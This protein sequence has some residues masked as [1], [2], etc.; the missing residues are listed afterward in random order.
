MAIIVDFCHDADFFRVF[1]IVSDSFGYDQPYIDALFPN[2]H[3]HAG[4]I[5]GADRFLQMKRTDPTNRCLKATDTASGE[6]I[7]FAKWIVFAN[8]K[9]E[10]TP[11]EGD[12]WETRDDKEYA[13]HVYEQYL[14]SRRS[15]ARSVDGPLVCLSSRTL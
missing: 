6:I 4:R 12:F 2:H 13:A 14:K 3:E 5:E 10:E 9:P 7:G 15:T 8:G 11:L 1:S